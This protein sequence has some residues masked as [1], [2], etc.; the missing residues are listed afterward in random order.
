MLEKKGTS[1]FILMEVGTG[2]RHYARE[3]GSST[4]KYFLQERQSSLITWEIAFFSC[5]A[6]FVAKTNAQKKND[7]VTST[8]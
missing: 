1:R 4:Y 7:F 5:A 8:N 3:A 6:A 2:L